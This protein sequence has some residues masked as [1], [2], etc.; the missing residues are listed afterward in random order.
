MKSWSI[1]LET[2][3]L[4]ELLFENATANTLIGAS[5][6]STVYAAPA[7]VVIFVPPRLLYQLINLTIV[8]RAAVLVEA[9]L[10]NES[11]NNDDILAASANSG[12]L[13]TADLYNCESVPKLRTVA[14]RAAA[15][16]PDGRSNITGNVASLA[17]LV[18]SKPPAVTVSADTLLS[19]TP[20][21]TDKIGAENSTTC[22]AF[23][24]CFI[25]LLV[26]TSSLIQ[27]IFTLYHKFIR[28]SREPNELYLIFVTFY[29]VQLVNDY[30][31]VILLNYHYYY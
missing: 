28:L 9:S 5:K 16:T 11:A 10:L 1:V 6:L 12:T 25:I 3:A 8:V 19:A 24:I 4:I 23:D 14:A 22:L 21:T 18:K 26:I 31:S 7:C 17:C 29:Y 30:F 13:A 20:P 2:S 27:F 15:L